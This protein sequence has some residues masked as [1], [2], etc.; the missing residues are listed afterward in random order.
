MNQRTSHAAILLSV[1]FVLS[2]HA[3]QADFPILQGPYIGQKPPGKRFPSVTPDGKYLFFCRVS[4]G[5]DFYW[6]DAK[7]IE[8]LSPTV[9]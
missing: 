2:S 7:I 9:R 3:Q 4:D 1:I 5:S 8:D 6:V